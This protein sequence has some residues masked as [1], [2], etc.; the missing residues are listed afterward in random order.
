MIH[1][2][3]QRPKTTIPPIAGDRFSL[4]FVTVQLAA[5]QVEA[6]ISLPY[7]QACNVLF[8]DSLSVRVWPEKMC[9]AVT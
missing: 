2:G 1:Q 7:C 5:V 3:T 6:D 4:P 9:A 8:L